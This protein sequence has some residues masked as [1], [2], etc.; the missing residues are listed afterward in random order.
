MG[1]ETELHTSLKTTTQCDGCWRN[2][3][4][5]V[6][7]GETEYEHQTDDDLTFFTVT[8]DATPPDTRSWYVAP[9][10]YRREILLCNYCLNGMYI[11]KVQEIVQEL[12]NLLAPDEPELLDTLE[13]DMIDVL[14]EGEGEGPFDAPDPL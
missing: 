3:V 4:V 5:E 1:I 14:N 7:D 9:E 13:V 8:L 10:Y 2:K 12:D 11:A 6:R